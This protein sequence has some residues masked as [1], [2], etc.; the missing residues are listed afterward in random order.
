MQSTMST[1]NLTLEPSHFNENG[2]AKIKCLATL[3]SMFWQEGDER[4]FGSSTRKAP[5]LRSINSS[6]VF[7]PV[8]QDDR[9]ASLL[10][11]RSILSQNVLISSVYILFL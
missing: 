4:V 8:F 3:T 5:D 6:P 9:E 2:D 1:L 7:S 11:M 10:G